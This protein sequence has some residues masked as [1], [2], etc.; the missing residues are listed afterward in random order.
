MITEKKNFLQHR[1]DT[2]TKEYA[3]EANNLKD[4]LYKLYRQRTEIESLCKD[5]DIKIENNENKD[6]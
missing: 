6:Q 1:L 5:L 3:L 4:L 2:L